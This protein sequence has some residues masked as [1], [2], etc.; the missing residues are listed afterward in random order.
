LTKKKKG[1]I[2]ESLK[3]EVN[4]VGQIYDFE[5]E[6]L[7]VGVIYNDMDVYDKALKMLTDAFGEI[8]GESERFSF[9]EEFSNYYDNELG[10]EGLRV[11]FSF[12]E[13]VD[14][15]KQAEIKEMT[16]EMERILSEDGNRK[17][18]L[19]PGFI[20]H[21]RLMLATTKSAG[22]RIPLKNGIYTELTLFWAKG[23]WH[24]LPWSY[25]DYQSEK[26]QKFITEVR[27]R[28]LAERKNTKNT[29]K[30]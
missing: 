16:N 26:V 12:K 13:H 10:G 14:A 20:N 21:G 6:K 9:S 15:S 18:N 27:K 8:D 7:I 4:T 11:I 3:C 19:D 17:I 22:F 2:I 30:A 5:K 29:E 1:V 23:E 25:R 24:K 28:Y